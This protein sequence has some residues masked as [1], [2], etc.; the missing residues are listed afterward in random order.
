MA[1]LYDTLAFVFRYWFLFIA[2]MMLL[3]LVLNSR[4]EYRERKA[5]M[6][7][8][9]QYIGYLEIVGGAEE[10]YGL[11]IGLTV[12]NIVGSGKNADI[13]IDDKSVQKSHAMIARK[14]KGVVLEPLSNKAETRING[15]RAVRGHRI[16]TGDVVSFGH[17]DAKVYLKPQKGAEHDD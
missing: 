1:Q 3:L 5:V 12:E 14:G 16:S 8:V 9:G 7:E 2:A 6:G 11:R 17:I 15:R 13:I 10:S 4:A